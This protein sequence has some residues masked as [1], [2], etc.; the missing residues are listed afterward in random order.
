MRMTLQN[1]ILKKNNY[2]ITVET[3]KN[4]SNSYKT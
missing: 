2:E 4:Y 3:I 1:K